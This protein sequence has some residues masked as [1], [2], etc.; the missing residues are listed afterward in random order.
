MEFL[1]VVGGGIYR[2]TSYPNGLAA[3]GI[4]IEGGTLLCSV[5]GFHSI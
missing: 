4:G 1:A 2:M 5:Y 3:G